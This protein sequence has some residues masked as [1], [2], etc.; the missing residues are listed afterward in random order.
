MI[1]QKPLFFLFFFF[2]LIN[3][4]FWS[5]IFLKSAKLTHPRSQTKKFFIAKCLN[6][7]EKNHFS[8]TSKINSSI[9]FE[10]HFLQNNLKE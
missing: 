2:K 5:A 7:F 4:F 9:L 6:V 1:F 10:L 3:F 8:L